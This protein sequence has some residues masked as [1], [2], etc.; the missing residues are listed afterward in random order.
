MAD[1]VCSLSSAAAIPR[2]G[3]EPLVLRGYVLNWGPGSQ[4][5]PGS[6][7]ANISKNASSSLSCWVPC[8]SICV[9]AEHQ[10]QISASRA[11]SGRSV[12]QLYYARLIGP[13]LTCR[14]VVLRLKLGHRRGGTGLERR[15]LRGERAL[16][17]VSC[18]GRSAA[19]ILFVVSAC[20][21]GPI[22]HRF[23]WYVVYSTIFMFG[24][25]HALSS[26]RSRRQI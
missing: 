26:V 3:T 19:M 1:V 24:P 5:N 18:G 6:S 15:D 16:K 25:S 9:F 22:D 13:R 2:L 17:Q 14:Q 7:D 10:R 21:Y 11:L 8:C 4:L 20:L 23:F 12:D